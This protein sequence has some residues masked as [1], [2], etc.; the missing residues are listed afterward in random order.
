MSGGS[1]H[2]SHGQGSATLHGTDPGSSQREDQGAEGQAATE[3]VQGSHAAVRGSRGPRQVVPQAQAGSVVAVA[4]RWAAG[5][6]GLGLHRLQ[7]PGG[8]GRYHLV[9]GTG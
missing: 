6:L 3:E 4:A 8:G 1:Y 7:V 2:G 9:A 5:A